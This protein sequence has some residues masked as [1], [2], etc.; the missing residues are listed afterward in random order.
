M[1]LAIPLTHLK[2]SKLNPRKHFDKAKLTDLA[3]NIR[4]H[5]V[6]T[7]L[8]VRPDWC[9]GLITS[10]D[11]EQA[12]V[13]AP[14]NPAS[15]EI[16]SGGRRYLAANMVDDSM[17]VP[18]RILAL[19]DPQVLAINLSEQIQRND[20]TPLEE[21]DAFAQQLAFKDEHG[22]PLHSAESLAES[23]GK[24]HD[25]VL[26]RLLL[27]QAPGNLKQ[28]LNAGKVSPSVVERIARIP[29]EDLR[30]QAGAEALSGGRDGEPMTVGEVEHLVRDRFMVQ[31]KGAPFNTAD[32]Q[33][34]PGA[35]SCTTCPMRT[36]NIAGAVKRGGR[37]DICTNPTC[38]RAKCQA[39]FLDVAAEAKAKGYAVLSDKDSARHFEL[40][41]PTEVRLDGEWVDLDTK[42]MA[43]LLQAEVANPPLWRELL[44]KAEAA[45]MTPE[46]V[47]AK[48]G[49]GRARWLVNSTLL[50]AAAE[51]LGEPI[52]KGQKGAEDAT[53]TPRKGEDA[54]DTFARGKRE[55]AEKLRQD[56][57]AKAEEA[58]LRDLVHGAQLRAVH[59]GL[60]KGWVPNTIWEVMLDLC[61]LANIPEQ[62]VVQKLFATKE[63]DVRKL[64]KVLDKQER[65][66]RQALVP[67]LLGA[68]AMHAMPTSLAH[69]PLASFA[70]LAAVDLKAVAK[71]A[72]E[73]PAKP[74][75]AKKRSAGAKAI[76]AVKGSI[77]GKKRGAK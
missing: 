46:V 6:L 70:R 18:C 15:F 16:V 12:R 45:G 76:A 33:L 73:P 62:W 35:G 43:H 54:D 41:H 11:L 65:T 66:A 53:V 26:E 34:L 61:G 72:V 27:R 14:A 67:L 7:N 13:N 29:D 68:Q 48:D 8:I 50:I 75:K 52:F 3:E 21:A 57:E 30:E 24:G 38:Y 10:T 44:E 64:R 56:S 4:V 42:P 49:S 19:T 59:A 32:P 1:D 51:K 37:S 25:Y 9:R 69:H 17:V 47:L 22:K 5:G 71:A 40:V 55:H 74:A 23:V 60:V 36:G 58:R 20:L 77:K 31:L 63:T 39:A 2:P 28:A